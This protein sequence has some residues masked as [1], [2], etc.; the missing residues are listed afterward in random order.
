VRH[1]RSIS[2][3]LSVLVHRGHRS[4]ESIEYRKAMFYCFRNSEFDRR[5]QERIFQGDE[6]DV[7]FY[8]QL[9]VENA[10]EEEVPS[11]PKGLVIADNRARGAFDAHPE[12]EGKERFVDDR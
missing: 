8:V 6:Q 11:C 4:A 12:F 1:Q 2:W 7:R 10:Q 5:M 3:R 9:T